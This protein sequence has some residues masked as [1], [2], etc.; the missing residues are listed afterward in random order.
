MNDETG[1]FDDVAQFDDLLGD[2]RFFVVGFGLLL[3]KVDAALCAVEA[4]VTSH[5]AD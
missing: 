1:Y 4:Q 3:Q 5:D 2:S